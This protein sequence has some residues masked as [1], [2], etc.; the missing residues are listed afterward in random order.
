[1]AYSLA[2]NFGV[3]PTIIPIEKTTDKLL[4]DC[5][6]KA[7]ET[8]NLNKGDIVILSGGIPLEKKVSVT[9][10]MKIEEI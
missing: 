3:Y 6:D 10:F 9:N 8:F 5:I 7:K 4:D 2:L 1:M